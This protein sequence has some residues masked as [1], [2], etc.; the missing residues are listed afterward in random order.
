MKATKILS[1]LL[2][3]VMVLGLAACGGE[4]S[5][6]ESTAA[7]AVAS[8]APAEETVEEA[9]VAEEAPAEEAAP[10]DSAAEEAPAEGNSQEAETQGDPY[11]AMDEEYITYPLEGD[12]LSISMWYY[13]PGYTDF[14]TSNNDFA[15]L[16]Y[17]EEATGVKLDFTEVSDSSASEQFNLMIAAGDMCDLIPAREYYTNGL[18]MAYEE[19]III[20]INEYVEE[21]MPNYAA[22]Y[23]CLDEQTQQDVLTDG[24][25][26]AFSTIAD[27]SYSGNGFVTRA[28]WIEEMGWEWSGNTISMDE[29]T[30]Y[31]RA[32]KE[33]YD[34][35]YGYYLYDGTIGVEAGF[36]TEIPALVPDGFMT[37]VTSAIYREGDTVK[38]GWTTDGYREYI[39]WVL[40]MMD[41]GI[42]Y[43][44]FLSLDSDRLVQN[45][46]QGTG[47]IGIW[48]ANA[49]KL[50]ECAAYAIEDDYAV[51]AV[52]N[53]TKD[54]SE[55]YVWLQEQSLVTTNS[56]F[57]I[58]TDCE[59]IDL[60]CQWMNYFW[61]TDG[62]YLCNYGAEGWSYHMDGDTAVF[63]WDLPTTVTG[64]NAPNAE[65]AQ[66]LWTMAR[67]T[68]FYSD[69]DRLLPTFPESALAA[70]ETWTMDGTDERY[71]PTSLETGFTVDENA[72][73]AEYEADMLTYAAEA[74]LKFMTG[75]VELTDDSWNEFV[76]TMESM[77]L[78]DIIA[79]Y[80]N[81]Y[82]QY[83]AGER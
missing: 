12:D 62:W 82:D 58:S 6:A 51:C 11:A 68:S 1:L 52:P 46:M 48:T 4:A 57:S 21:Y 60:V 45:Q 7:E 39:E 79:V 34:V 17:A 26:L 47:E 63:D 66:N 30:E 54:T 55:P 16:P 38:S 77:G 71:Y 2:A 37:F 33:T 18:S 22:V 20:D 70:I 44:D 59:Q 27:G 35:P 83:L 73:I 81:A 56:G 64:K 61:T 69:H 49:D 67:F 10:A 9:P 3:L 53:V 23:A 43:K 75:A 40:Q 5:V 36:D 78:N 50:E 74:C 80:Q 25:M 8:S 31:L 72:E 19:D 28:D 29:F 42:I 13:I 76:S 65:M 14:C 15:A 24:M 41:E 32:I